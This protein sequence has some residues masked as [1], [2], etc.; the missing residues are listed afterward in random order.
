MKKLFTLVLALIIVSASFG[1]TKFG[2]KAGLN[3][4]KLTDVTQGGSTDEIWNSQTGYHVGLAVQF[5]VPFLGLAVQPELLY[6]TVKSSPTTPT[7]LQIN[8]PLYNGGVIS[9]PVALATNEVQ[10]DYIMLPVNLQFG[11]DLVLLRPFV[12]VS[13]Y[14][15]YAIQ[16]G[17]RLESQPIDD[18]NRFD[19]GL[20]LGVGLDLW[21]L[22][23]MGKYNWGLGKLKSANN[24]TWNEKYENAKL[25]GFQ[26][27]VAFLF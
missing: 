26:L 9:Q 6:N 10:M 5:K 17:A 12:V 22:Q 20:G 16:S 18:I 15:Q 25:Q 14:I 1:Q 19:Y 23:I 21:K 4:N 24:T 13:P 7:L 8:N 2:V 3:F 27:S 11:I